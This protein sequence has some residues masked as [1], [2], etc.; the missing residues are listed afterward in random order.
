[1]FILEIV[2]ISIVAAVVFIVIK[3]L[4]RV[5]YSKE[6]IAILGKYFGEQDFSKNSSLDDLRHKLSAKEELN[7]KHRKSLSFILNDI[8]HKIDVFRK[9]KDH[10][11]KSYDN[12]GIFKL[13][14]NDI[15]SYSIANE[16]KQKYIIE[17]LFL[18]LSDKNFLAGLD[19][20]MSDIKTIKTFYTLIPET[21]L[22]YEH[23]LKSK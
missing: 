23:K 14:T 4:I 20:H 10:F 12:S 6:S 2:L 15:V 11:N 17:L 21:L 8:N 9:H 22:K 3:L 13:I 5:Q 19:V 18:I 7:K 16:K 1:M